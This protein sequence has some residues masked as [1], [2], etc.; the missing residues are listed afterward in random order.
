MEEW[1]VNELESTAQW[2]QEKA[3]QYPDDE[4]NAEA[5]KILHQL[6]E[7]LRSLPATPEYNRYSAIHDFIFAEG[8]DSEDTNS[9]RV[10][11]RW[12]EYRG[13]IGFNNFPSSAKEYLNDLIEIACEVC[14]AA[15]Y[16]MPPQQ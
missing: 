13:R 1:L 6:A 8:D 7:E 11:E 4:R 14:P 2:R 10:A 12:N 16:L 3:E 9:H 5:S 15:E